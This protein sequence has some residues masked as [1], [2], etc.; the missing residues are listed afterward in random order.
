[1][2]SSANDLCVE[3]FLQGKLAF[4]EIPEVIEAVLSAVPWQA[5]PDLA[6]ILETM[7][8]TQAETRAILKSME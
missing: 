8:L 7:E 5:Q 6:G 1:M 4:T 3:A 2:L